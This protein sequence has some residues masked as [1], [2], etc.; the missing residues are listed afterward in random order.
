VHE[1]SPCNRV[2]RE[3][4]TFLGLL[5][6]YHALHKKPKV[7]IHISN[8]NKI[9]LARYYINLVVISDGEKQEDVAVGCNYLQFK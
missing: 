6:A 1:R 9:H 4:P 5:K 8:R 2:L 3:Y 7:L